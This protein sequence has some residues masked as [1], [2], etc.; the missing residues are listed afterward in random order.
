MHKYQHDTITYLTPDFACE[1]IS[2]EML[3]DVNELI[4]Q[5]HILK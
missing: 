3:L 5:T 4:N 2:R 1:V